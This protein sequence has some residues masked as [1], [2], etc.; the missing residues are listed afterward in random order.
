MQMRV[1][2]PLYVFLILMAGTLS[3]QVTT[4]RLTGTVQDASGAAV[5]GATVTA[6]NEETGQVRSVTLTESGI[7]TFD[8]VP[9]G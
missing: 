5:S 4:S 3:A 9:T 6:R 2:C 8:A 7:F 1:R